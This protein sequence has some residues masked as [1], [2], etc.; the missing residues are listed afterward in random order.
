MWLDSDISNQPPNTNRE[1][2]NINNFIKLGSITQE[3]S[4]KVVSLYNKQPLYILPINNN[5]LVLFNLDNTIGIISDEVYTQKHSSALGFNSSTIISCDFYINNIG[6]RIVVFVYNLGTKQINIDTGEVEDLINTSIEPDISSS[7]LNYGNLQVGSYKLFCR[8]VKKD[9]STTNFFRNYEPIL[10]TDN[11]ESGSISN[12][13][14]SVTISGIDLGYKYLELGYVQV[15]DGI[16]TAYIIKKFDTKSTITYTITETD[17]K[18]PIDLEELINDRVVYKNI[19]NV[20]ITKDYLYG[21]GVKY[22][23]ELDNIQSIT[24]NLVPK[25]YSELKT[26]TRQTSFKTFAHGE[27]Y[28][29]YIRY[30]FKWGYSRWYLLI[31]RTSGGTEK[32]TTTINSKTYFKYQVEDNCTSL[33]SHLTGTKGTFSFW[34]NEQE[35]YPVDGGYPIGKVRHFKFPSVNWMRNNLYNTATYGVNQFDSLGVYIDNIDLSLIKDN[36]NVAAYAYEIGYAKRTPFNSLVVGQSIQVFNDRYT[37]IADHL[38]YTNGNFFNNGGNF[39]SSYGGNNNYKSL[40]N[41]KTYPLELLVNQN[42]FSIDSFREEI[43]LA[44][45]S[46]AIDS[47]ENNNPLHDTHSYSRIISDFTLTGAGATSTA[48]AANYINNLNRSRLI[49]NNTIKEDT[50]NI[51]S[52]TNYNVAVTS[53]LEALTDSNSPIVAG[54]KVINTPFVAG[55]EKTKLITLLHDNKNCYIDFQNQDIL[56]LN[57]IS[58]N[59][60]LG[61]CFINVTDVVLFGTYIGAYREPVQT[62]TADDKQGLFEGNACIKCFISESIYNFSGIKDTLVTHYTRENSYNTLYQITLKRDLDPNLFNVSINKDYSTYNDLRYSKVVKDDDT[63]DSDYFIIRSGNISNNQVYNSREF[64]PNDIYL[65]PKNKGRVTNIEE[66]QDFLY[67][68]TETTLFRT[69]GANKAAVDNTDN[70][71]YIKVG[72]IF[73]TPLFEVQH[74]E[75][76]LMGTKHKHSCCLSEYGYAFIDADKYK[77]FLIGDKDIKVLSSDGLINKFKE[78]LAEPVPV[79]PFIGNGIS[80]EFDE[81]T[82]RLFVVIKDTCL[83]YS[84]VNQ[85]WLC[86]TTYL[87][88]FVFRTRTDFYSLKNNR[89]YKHNVSRRVNVIYGEKINS[90]CNVVIPLATKEQSQNTINGIEFKNDVFDALRFKNSYQDSGEVELFEISNGE[91]L[92]NITGNV[93]KFRGN[94]LFYDIRDYCTDS[95]F[96]DSFISI[97]VIMKSTEPKELSQLSLI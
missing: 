97:D 27:V 10:I 96:I 69:V 22:N 55:A 11:K 75:L 89:I 49:L 17:N 65:V 68:H 81:Y 18:Q 3:L 8:Y 67:I 64:S 44:T 35:D 77:M 37:G 72:D 2:Y 40:S 42:D 32:D 80:V 85:G 6:E 36:N 9:K 20:K 87:P 66:G 53:N 23:K 43:K 57:R 7:I 76:G 70:L 48:I 41:F 12:K 47:D 25:W 84:F 24:N 4:N 83:I 73:Q 94:F 50:N 91:I 28:A 30:K 61:D 5:D 29:L 59:I 39:I 79:S 82:E 95:A 92:Q 26:P 90:T 60:F 33:G 51:Y 93:R 38:K 52:E 15:K 71:L 45:L 78:L 88:D 19:N 56:G 13:S 46:G 74:S 62:S 16:Q 54:K 58:N 86:F 31:G 21:Y 63:N 14:I 34:E 1:S